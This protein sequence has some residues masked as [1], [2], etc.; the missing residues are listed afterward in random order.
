MTAEPTK[1]A[2][3]V[4]HVDFDAARVATLDDMREIVETGERQIADARPAGRFAGA[5]PEPRPGVRGGH[6]P[7]AKSVPVAD[8]VAATASCCRPTSC[9]EAFE[10]AGVDLVEAGRHLVRLRR[11]RGGHHAGAGNAWPQGQQ[12]L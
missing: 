11:H 4:F 10:E 3:N 1:I 8:A 6:M 2:P 7:G 12:A 5:D 9:S